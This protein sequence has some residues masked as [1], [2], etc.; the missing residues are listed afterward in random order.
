MKKISLMS[1][2]LCLV[3]SVQ[4]SANTVKVYGDGYLEMI[5]DLAILHVKGSEFET[6]KQYGYLVGDKVAAN[7][8]NLK[9]I[10]AAEQSE[11]KLLPDAIFTWLRRAVGF[12]FWL[13][14]QNNVKTHIKGMIEGAKEAGVKLNKYDVTFI[15]SI[16]DIVGIAKANVGEIPSRVAAKPELSWI[17]K[18]LGLSKF[19]YNCDSLAVWGSRT[20]DGKTFQ[21]RNTDITTGVGIERYPLAIIYKLDGK[22]PFITAAFSGMIGIFS[23]MNAYGVALGQVWA[24]SKDV[25]LT[26]PWNIVMRK[27]FSENSSAKRVENSLRRLGSTT[28]GNNFI[29]ADAGGHENSEDTGFA[30]EMTAKRYASFIANDQREL[31]PRYEGVP[32][33]YPITEGVLRAD[34]S[35][36][37]AI[38][39]RQLSGNGPD[40]DARNSS[41]YVNRYKGQYDRIKAYEESGILMGQAE[42]ESISRETAMRGSSLQTAV[43][44]NTD[45]EMWV[46]YSKILD[47]GTVIQAY[48]QK[49]THI[50]FYQYLIDLK[51][52]NGM[53][54]IKNWF[55]ERSR[56]KLLHK[57]AQKQIQEI[58]IKLNK[59]EVLATSITLLKG[60]TIELYDGTRL[61][62]RL[63]NK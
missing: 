36:D 22:I 41:S 1:F 33:G 10:G 62:D 52:E 7:V 53:V 38:R 39:S 54:I 5:D 18:V 28:Y 20:Q 24:F 3:F 8:A 16:I 47:N 21:S 59:N 19:N 61:I 55:K 63:T 17:L 26:T 15:N 27:Y 30:I 42:V 14:L 9:S 48:E 35:L 56:L 40:G 49:Y 31:L 44:A 13:T 51:L 6:G 45:R 58:D 29:V 23:G 25:K 43:Y 32:Y 60:D 46:S 4:T 2:F 11:I 50:P 34:I 12:V 57:N 37:L